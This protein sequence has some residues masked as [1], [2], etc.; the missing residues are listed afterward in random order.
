MTTCRGETDSCHEAVPVI[1]IPSSF[2][3]A[4]ADAWP[5]PCALRIEA[6]KK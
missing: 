2:T 1:P 3:E 5:C 4:L 6:E